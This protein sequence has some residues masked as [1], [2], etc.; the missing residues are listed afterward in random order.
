MITIPA[1]EFL[2]GPRK[3]AVHLP[4]YRLA[5][6]P[7]TNA[8]YQAFVDDTGYDPP[9]PWIGG[10]FTPG[11]ELHPVVYVSWFDAWAFCEWAGCRLPAELEW[12]KGARG[13]DG[14]RYPWGDDWRTG[15][16]QTKERG[17]QDTSPVARY[18]KGASSYGLMD[19]AGNVWEW[20][21]G[22]GL[23]RVLRGGSWLDDRTRAISTF[24]R[25][26]FPELR[27]Y[28]YGFRCSTGLED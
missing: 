18:P 6:T 17:I 16:C 25:R 8:Q 15:F 24:R 26:D 19:M 2:Q 11:R 4:E 21:D 28:D 5:K 13:V 7:I 22:R 10:Q 23:F 9:R 12:E 27:N 3:E 14:R 1:G 20:C